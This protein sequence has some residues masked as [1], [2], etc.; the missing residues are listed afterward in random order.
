[1]S[2]WIRGQLVSFDTAVTEAAAMLVAAR[3]PVIAGLA[4]DVDAVRAAFSLGATIGASFDPA[5]APN[6]YA[7]LAVFARSGA[8]TTTPSELLQRADV[9]VAIGAR[10]ARSAI[11][12]SARSSAPIVGRATGP[13]KI[14]TF[15]V[16]NTGEPLAPSLAL[17]R[18]LATGRLH[19]EHP[20]AEIARALTTAQFGVAVYDPEEL[21]E[22]A[23]EMLQGLVAELSET[24][25][26]FTLA[27]PDDWQSRCALQVSTWTAACGPRLGLGRSAPEHDPWR[28]DAARQAGSG[29]ID[30]VLWLSAFDAP[31]PP[32]LADLPSVSLVGEPG[33]TAGQIVFAV[34]VPGYTCD[35]V[36][37]DKRIGTL[38]Y[39][40]ARESSTYPKA[41]A[42]IRAVEQAVHASKGTPC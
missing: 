32:W 26:F 37:W 21:G 3:S 34:G 27:L 2:T 10:A 20:A 39:A 15:D 5:G 11:L 29:E 35:G 18:A 38:T 4:S 19:A 23:V 28:F 24:T 9:V 8:M 13:R 31:L 14:L 42:V 17:L 12:D 41:A 36:V 7:E 30:A 16:G 6:L 33:E 25:R 1:M 40:A 22:L